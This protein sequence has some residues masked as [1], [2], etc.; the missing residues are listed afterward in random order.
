[1][2][3]KIFLPLIIGASISVPAVFAKVSHRAATCEGKRYSYRLFIPITPSQKSPAIL[4]LH[5]AGDSPDPM[6]DEWKSLADGQAIVLVAPELPRTVEFEAVA[7]SVFHCVM[8]DAKSVASLDEKRLFVFGNSMGGYLAYDAAAFQSEYFAAVG[9][10]AMGIDPQYD[11]ILE[12]AKRKIP[13]IIY[14]GDH[15]PLVSLKNVRRTKDLLE[16][17]GF[18]VQ[19]EELKGHDHNYYYV[20]KQVNAGVWQFFV[21]HSLP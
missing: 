1:M 19:Y 10:H 14:M 11:R 7:P 2:L 16:N 12:Q 8:E 20:A 3:K 15:D 9:V 18:P 13:F 4:L 21:T 6:I 17:R 5:G